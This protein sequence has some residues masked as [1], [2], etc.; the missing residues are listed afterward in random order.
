M[1]LLMKNTLV[2]AASETTAGTAETLAAGDAA[3]NAYD[4]TWNLGLQVE[5]REGQ[6]GFGKLAGIPGVTPATVSFKTDMG[7][8]GTATEQD[9]A[10][11]L[12]PACGWVESSNTFDP[13]S[14]APGSNVKTLTIGCYYNGKR[15]LV[16]GAVGTFRVVC[17]AGKMTYIEW[18][19]TGVFQSDAD[20]AILSPTYP[21]DTILKY[22]SATTTFS[23]VSLCVSQMTFAAGNE[24]YLL[25]C[26]NSTNGLKH[27]VIVDR[28]PTATADPESVLVA[29]QDRY[30][31][32]TAGT[33]AA[34]SVT[35]DGPST[36]TLQI[37]APKAQITS[38][39]QGDRSKVYV[40]NL[41]WDCEKNGATA[42]Q[43]L[44]F[45][46]TPTA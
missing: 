8:D 21:T 40:D 7:W 3:Y 37:T 45:I 1:V 30:G 27:G 14:E 15:F 28:N 36:S 16:A 17:P 13:K 41:T 2:A 22:S 32:W 6:G 26:G 44:R 19:F 33:Q 18:T 5:K 34:L 25:E 11:V 31:A 39:G 20:A 9:W 46:F 24:I 42:D 12:L 10:A 38:L 4:L 35:L 23:G 29:T 43:E